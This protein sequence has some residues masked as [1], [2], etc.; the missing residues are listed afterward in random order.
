MDILKQQVRKY[1]FLLAGIYIFAHII[2]AIIV[3]YNSHILSVEYAPSCYRIYSMDDFA[4]VISLVGNILIAFCMARDMKRFDAFS[5]PLILL[6][7]IH[8]IY[9]DIL[10]LILIYSNVL[11]SKKENA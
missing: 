8:P 6:A 1:A 4:F 9:S 3:L 7:L 11:N 2:T 5:W 10:Y